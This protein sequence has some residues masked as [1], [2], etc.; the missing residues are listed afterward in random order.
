MKKLLTLICVLS[1]NLSFGKLI[2]YPIPQKNNVFLELSKGHQK[3]LNP[4][5]IKLLVWNLHK[6]QDKPFSHDFQ[7]LAKNKDILLLQEMYLTQDMTNL[8]LSMKDYGFK[9]A[10]SFF[11]PRN[12]K[13]RTGVSSAAM[14]EPTLATFVRTETLEPVINTP[15]VTMITRYPIAGTDKILTVANIHSINFVTPSEFK[16]E[17]ERVFEELKK[18]PKP[19]IFAGDFNTWLGEKIFYLDQLRI[20]LNMKEAVFSPDNRMNKLGYYLDHFLY[21]D[22]LSVVTATANGK[23][24]GSDH[25]PLEVELKYTPDDN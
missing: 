23:Y 12:P 1:T 8:F 20:S 5:S 6:G 10:T 2:Q 4:D 21:T 19:I 7:I 24:L 17:A 14:V 13:I 15:K 3:G 18:Y 9:T 25:K 11:D 22:D 16:L